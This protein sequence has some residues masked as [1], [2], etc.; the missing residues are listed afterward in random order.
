[1]VR[2][3]LFL[4]PIVLFG[5]ATNANN[6][7]VSNECRFAKSQYQMCYGACL[8]STPGTFLQAASACGRACRGELNQ[9]NSTCR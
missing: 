5:C 3:I 1:M 9:M 8:S 2:S 4:I 7:N 6:A